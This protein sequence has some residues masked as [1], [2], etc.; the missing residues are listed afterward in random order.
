MYVCSK[1]LWFE[2]AA[3]MSLSSLPFSLSASSG[4][5]GRTGKYFAIEHYPEV[6]PDIMVMA[7]VCSSVPHLENL[8]S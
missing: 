5:F 1:R 6:V 7:K 3:L 8:V 4:G 2:V